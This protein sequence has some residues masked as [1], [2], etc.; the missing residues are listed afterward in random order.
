VT[1]F[2]PADPRALT[3]LML[4]WEEWVALPDLGLPALKAKI[5]TGAKTSAL[6]AYAIER[7]EVRGVA[8]VRFRIHPA[9]RRR[10]IEILCTA[11]IKDERA[12]VSSNG[13][14]ERRFV[15]ETTIAIAGQRWPID[16]TLTNREG[17]NSR[18]LLGRQALRPGILIDPTRAF[19]LPRLKY[20]LYGGKK[21][22]V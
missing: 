14:S 16:I 9:R 1:R 4:G 7:A 6:H 12:V 8:M 10:D 19:L 5:D 20:A 13:E 11:P 15:I 22:R 3:T 2:S 17:M 18:M 21:R